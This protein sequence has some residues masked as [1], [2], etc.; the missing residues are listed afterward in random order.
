MPVFSELT[1]SEERQARRV[2]LRTAAKASLI[3]C[4][5]VAIMGDSISRYY[6]WYGKYIIAQQSS[7]PPL[8]GGYANQ[9][10]RAT[11]RE[12]LLTRLPRNDI[13]QESLVPTL[14]FLRATYF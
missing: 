10:L 8:R 9:K 12:A 3:V 7:E 2:S 5:I 4:S 6:V 1:T 14:T 11:V 13:P